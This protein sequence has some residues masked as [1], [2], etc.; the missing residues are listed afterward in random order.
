MDP[1]SSSMSRDFK[2]SAADDRER[3]YWR[4][5]QPSK[6]WRAQLLRLSGW[7][8][9]G[10]FPKPHHDALLILGPGMDLG[11]STTSLAEYRL[12][13]L[14]TWFQDALLKDL[15]VSGHHLVLI[16]HRSP[17]LPD[18][19]KQASDLGISVQIIRVVFSVKRIRCNTPFTP[20]KYPERDLAYIR[21]MFTYNG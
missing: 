20:S 6:W 11:N 16:D 3:K 4:W 12:K 8:C 7:K 18:A 21:R 19:L 14:G 10:P 15:P 5:K 1:N 2:G 13:F 17:Q 9:E